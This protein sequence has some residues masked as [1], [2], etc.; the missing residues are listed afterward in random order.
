[1]QQILGTGP[2]LD[3]PAHR[4]V[5]RPGNAALTQVPLDHSSMSVA[6]GLA[7]LSPCLSLPPRTG[8][9]FRAAAQGFVLPLKCTARTC[10]RT[11]AHVHF[12]AVNCATAV[13]VLR[14]SFPYALQLLAHIGVRTTGVD[15]SHRVE[16]GN[17]AS[18]PVLEKKHARPVCSE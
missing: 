15:T 10:D 17:D 18:C 8:R 11:E 5:G 12:A 13:H 14:V 9:H 7:R 4:T 3:P 16:H 2:S 6:T 1:M